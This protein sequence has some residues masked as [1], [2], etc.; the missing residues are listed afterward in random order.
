MLGV[1]LCLLIGMYAVKCLGVPDVYV[2]TIQ[3]GNG[4]GEWWGCVILGSPCDF[5]FLWLKNDEEASVEGR[6]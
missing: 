3:S 4:K 2:N 6:E 5:F 1:F